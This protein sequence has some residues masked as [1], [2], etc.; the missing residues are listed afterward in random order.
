M[1][2]AVQ[3]FSSPV[4]QSSV[5]C[6]LGF[7]FS[8]P[9]PCPCLYLLHDRRDMGITE[10]KCCHLFVIASTLALKGSGN[11]CHPPLTLS[12]LILLHFDISSSILLENLYCGLLDCNAV[13][14]CR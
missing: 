2:S 1:R 3:N 10:L 13:Q 11:L 14:S 4:T 5:D 7:R 8:H 6:G 9:M 12:R